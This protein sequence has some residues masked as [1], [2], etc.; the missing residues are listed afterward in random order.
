M[1]SVS[2]TH[3]QGRAKNKLEQCS[4]GMLRLAMRL[5]RVHPESAYEL[6]RAEVHLRVRAVIS[7]AGSLCLYS[8]L[9][10]HNQK[11][12][13]LLHHL[14]ARLLPRH[15]GARVTSRSCGLARV[16]LR[17]RHLLHIVQLRTL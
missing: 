14:L 1:L 4:S 5:S 3:G 9:C 8:K 7:T 10:V 11:A 15:G 16:G 12:L 17:R 6:A 13:Q 2:S